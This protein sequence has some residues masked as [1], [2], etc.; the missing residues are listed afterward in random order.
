M[1]VFRGPPPGGRLLACRRFLSATRFLGRSCQSPPGP[2]GWCHTH[3]G[4]GPPPKTPS[5]S[6][7]RE[8]GDVKNRRPS[9]AAEYRRPSAGSGTASRSGAVSVLGGRAGG[10]RRGLPSPPLRPGSRAAGWPFPAGSCRESGR[11]HPPPP[12]AQRRSG[13][14]AKGDF[15]PGGRGSRE[16]RP[17]GGRG[18]R[19]AEELR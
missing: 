1:E 8:G 10:R 17:L 2:E 5:R 14:G 18:A 11:G 15:P 16:L 4:G 12:P 6:H 9:A 3:P 7:R 19:G 13:A